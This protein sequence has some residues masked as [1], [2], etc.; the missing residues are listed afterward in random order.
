MEVLLIVQIFTRAV[1]RL[2]AILLFKNEVFKYKTKFQVQSQYQTTSTKI[3]TSQ[4]N[5][6]ALEEM[7]ANKRRER[8]EQEDMAARKMDA[9]EAA[10]E[11]REENWKKRE[12]RLQQKAVI[13]FSY[14]KLYYRW[15]SIL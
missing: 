14:L 4:D 1:C 3:K 15:L 10:E 8:E 9:D 12:Q 11:K 13:T 5:R 2:P 7:R 6:R